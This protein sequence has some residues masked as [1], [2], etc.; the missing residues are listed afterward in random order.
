MD[1]LL[2]W[3]LDQLLAESAAMSAIPMDSTM[4]A[5]AEFELKTGLC[6]GL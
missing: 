4:Q 5:K 1:D 2:T 3:Q 6:W